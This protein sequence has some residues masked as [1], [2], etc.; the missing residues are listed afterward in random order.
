MWHELKGHD[1]GVMEPLIRARFI[2]YLTR[3]D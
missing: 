1:Y 2:D 3:G